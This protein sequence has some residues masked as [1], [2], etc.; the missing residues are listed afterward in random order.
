MRR[1]LSIIA[2][3]VLLGLSAGTALGHTGSISKQQSCEYG[4]RISAHLD[5]NVASS[6][7]F[8][9]KINGSLVDSG[10][11]PGPADLGPYDAGFGS[12]SAT[13]E[14]PSVFT[15]LAIFGGILLLAA[16]ILYARKERN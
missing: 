16:V 4:T 9:V 6:S 7:T 15:P 3:F 11:G 12:G 1:A 8:E 14:R 5:G 10:T 2:A 13:L